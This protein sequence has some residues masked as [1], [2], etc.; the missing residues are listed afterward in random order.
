MRKEIWKSIEG[1]DSRYQ[2]SNLGRVKSMPKTWVCG[3]K[4]TIRTKGETVMKQSICT[5]GYCQI[6]LSLNLKNKKYLV[7][8]LVALSFK[9]I[10]SVSQIL[11]IKTAI[12]VIIGRKT[13]NG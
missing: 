5:N 3:N 7:H 4:G 1:F 10:D 11:I 12:D 2:I 13:S 6:D 8:R 9:K